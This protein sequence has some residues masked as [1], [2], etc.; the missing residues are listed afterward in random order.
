MLSALAD[1]CYITRIPSLLTGGVLTCFRY[2]LTFHRY[3]FSYYGLIYVNSV[4]EKTC[5]LSVLVDIDLDCGGYLGKSGHC[6]DIAGKR[7]N[8]TCACRD[9][10]A[11]DGDIEVLG[12]AKLLG[13]ICEAVLCFGNTDR[14]VSESDAL[15]LLSLLGCVSSHN[16]AAQS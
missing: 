11:A 5:D 16:N 10:H 15:K 14:A 3:F 4:S 1:S 2:F 9:L 6:H 13:I 12:C 7:D 8:E